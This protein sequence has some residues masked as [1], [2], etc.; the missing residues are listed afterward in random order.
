MARTR[1]MV[2]LL[3]FCTQRSGHVL[4]PHRPPPP[5]SLTV[6][7]HETLKQCQ[8]LKTE[9]SQMDRR[10]NQL[11]EENGDLSFKVRVGVSG[12]HLVARCD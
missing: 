9:K 11:S 6:R 8:D 10:I 1:G 3:S 7:L 5:R 12:P 2:L 4:F